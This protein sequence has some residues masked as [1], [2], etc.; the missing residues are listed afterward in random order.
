MHEG[1]VCDMQS[2]VCILCIEEKALDGHFSCLVSN[3]KQIENEDHIT[4]HVFQEWYIQICI[5]LCITKNGSDSINI[6][7]AAVLIL[8]LTT[9]AKA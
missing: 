8:S 4:K 7:S 9:L 1:A 2:L 3:T 6:K 5:Y